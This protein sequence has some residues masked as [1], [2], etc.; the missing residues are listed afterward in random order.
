MN[1]SYCCITALKFHP[2]RNKDTYA[3]IQFQQINEAFETL[4]DKAKRHIYDQENSKTAT[5]L[6]F[7]ASYA[8]AL[9]SKFFSDHLP[10]SPAP[11]HKDN[12]NK[13]QAI[14]RTL[15]VSLNDIYTG[16]TKRLKITRNNN[17]FDPTLLT[18]HVK[19]GVKNGTTYTYKGQGDL[20]PSGQCQDIELEIQEK[21][22][23]IYRRQGD[24]L[25][26]TVKLTLLEALTGF[27]KA[28]PKL[29]GQY[30][31][32]CSQKRVI[33]SGQQQ[34]LQGEGMPNEITGVK[35]NLIIQ[36]QVELPQTLSSEQCQALQQILS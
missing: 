23:E 5:H 24:H 16:A 10:C 2:D 18:L 13:P 32:I 28:I 8:E 33:Q 12:T 29:D 30:F 7:D 36:F 19:P 34:V 4:S 9:F 22:H 17:L 20:L 21:P 27:K 15:P 26:T 14:K 25:F 31:Y 35:G 3:K 6:D 1:L 11:T